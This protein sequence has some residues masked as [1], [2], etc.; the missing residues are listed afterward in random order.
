M[1]DQSPPD[2]HSQA[3]SNDT[4]A[5]IEANS[6][7]GSPGRVGQAT[8]VEQSRAVAEVQSAVVMA[9]AN[10]RDSKR[11]LAQMRE[12]CGMMRL[13]ERAFFRFP[14]GGQTVSGASVTAELVGPV[15]G[16]RLTIFKKKRRK[17]HRRKMG[18]RQD[19]TQIRITGITAG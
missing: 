9:R 16:E 13:A 7:V 19:L 6:P 8:A 10:P 3:P 4:P 5:K 11:A 12:S 1:N 18:H 17:H 15:R 14:R 2:W